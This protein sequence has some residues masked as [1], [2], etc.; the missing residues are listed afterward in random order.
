MTG[1]VIIGAG[2]AGYQ[3]VE[4]LR[5]EGYEGLITLVGEE[6]HLPYQRPPLSKDYLLGKT[7]GERI[8]YR[9][10]EFYEQSPVT[11]KLA[12]RALSINQQEKTVQCDGDHAL[13]YD[14]L[15]LA[16]GARVRKLE[17]PGAALDGICYLR[18]LDDVA[19]IGKRLEA[20]QSVIVIGAGFIGLEF[21]SV[22]RK[23]GK[24]VTVLE[25]MER[26]MARVVEPE[27]SQFFT[28]LHHSHGVEIITGAQV[29]E[30]VGQGGQLSGVKTTDGLLLKAD[31]VVVGIGVLPNLELAQEAGLSCANGIIV[32]EFGQ[33][34]NADIYACGDCASY[35]HPFAGAP[36]RLESVQN[37]GDQARSVAA[38]ITGKDKS[39]IAVPWFWSDQYDVKLQMTGLTIGCDSHVVRGDLQS[40]H[41]SLWHYKRNQLRAIEAISAPRDYVVGRMLLEKKI[42]P[43]KQ[44]ASNADFNLKPLLKQPSRSSS[45]KLHSLYKWIFRL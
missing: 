40:G 30:I 18:T 25:A 44:Q 2:Q 38:K 31:L 3:C 33:T 22:A 34:S 39:Y 5:L 27:L 11:L 21:A 23:L 26:V 9:P 13:A 10:R 1:V 4:S 32:N 36:V 28:N 20:A 7:D 6:S 8:L 12:T 43:T 41:F 17:L 29:G 35:E 45:G 42:S 24:K 14:A 15:I 37:A 16:T 19:D